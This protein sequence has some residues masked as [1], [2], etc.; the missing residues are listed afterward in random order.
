M[1]FFDW[2]CKNSVILWFHSPKDAVFAKTLPFGN[3]LHFTGVNWVQTWT[4]TVKFEYVSFLLKH[5]ILK[6]CWDNFF[7][8]WETNLAQNLSKIEPY[9][10]KKGPRNHPKGTISWMLHRHK[11]IWAFITCEPQML[12]WWKLPPLY[13]SMRSLIWCKN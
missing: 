11:T 1:D 4:K 6:D 12:Y 3:V 13:I 2:F 8:L 9:L 5:K 10:G 7:A